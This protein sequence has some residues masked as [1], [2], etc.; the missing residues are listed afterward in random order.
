MEAAPTTTATRSYW[1]AGTSPPVLDITVGD[2]LRAAATDAPETV[3]LIDGCPDPAER[4]SWTYTELVAESERVARWL[5]EHFEPGERLLIV[6]PNSASWVIM[7]M[8]AAL[9]GLVLATANP[10][11][12]ERELEYV[13]RRS[14]AVGVVVADSYRGHDLRATIGRLTAELPEVRLVFNLEGLNDLPPEAPRR[15]P[16][17]EVRPEDPAQI[18]YTGGT[19]GFPK[20][21]VLHHRGIANTPNFVLTQAGMRTGDTWIN[22]MPLFHVGGCVTTGLGIVGRRG[23]HV[24]VPEFRPALLLELIEALGGNMSLLVPTMLVRVLEH[25]DMAIR[26]LSS[27]HTIVS[28]AAPVPAELIRR[29]KRAFSCQFTNIFGQTEVSGVVTTTR[30]EDTPE[31]QA[32]T[33]GRAVPHVEI[34]IADPVT[35]EIAPLDAEGEICARGH[36]TMIGYLD[37]RASTA[38]TLREDGWLHTGDLGSMDERGYLRITG[39]LKDTI[40]RGGE[41]ISPREV[42]EVLYTHPNVAEAI[43]LGVPD[44]EWGEEV[45]AVIRAVDPSIPPSAWE[46]R[47]HCRAQIARFK[48]PALWVFVEAYPTTA[49]GKIQKFALREEIVAGRLPIE[50]VR[51]PSP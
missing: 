12:Q 32:E 48:A 17:P 13:L 44:Q 28:G 38:A 6:A 14:R 50:R 37:D 26:D 23:T 4:R 31:D 19:T 47:E 22:V 15:T 39:R 34:K 45:A 16:M 46:L 25:S 42:E 5:L 20:G 18:Q 1:R 2:L 49:A 35:G 29:T 11:Y 10:A 33:I 36:Q 30:V 43:V 27:V 8:A 40:I 24:V 7:Q 51:S 9:A 21:V 3:A 41:N